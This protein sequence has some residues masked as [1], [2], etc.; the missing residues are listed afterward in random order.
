MKATC[1]KC[2]FSAD[3]PEHLAG[4]TIQ[5]PKCQEKFACED[6]SSVFT[7]A[8]EFVEAPATSKDE[9]IA[10]L[11]LKN[12]NLTLT[13]KRLYGRLTV[14]A[15]NETG[16]RTEDVNV[17]L[18]EV[19]NV[20]LTKKP[21]LLSLIYSGFS[22]LCVI[23]LVALSKSSTPRDNSLFLNYLPVIAV[24]CLFGF[25]IRNKRH[26]FSVSLTGKAFTVPLAGSHLYFLRAAETADE[27]SKSKDFIAQVQ[28]AK[29]RYEETL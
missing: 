3:A 1:P 16:R 6:A 28:E 27:L 21:N 17:P 26:Y 24:V 4:K 23:G 10:T 15:I 18:N 14:E 7:V 29:K 13:N 11:Q 9:P 8:E 2:G 22:V 5:C 12:A 19:T 25:L 20:S